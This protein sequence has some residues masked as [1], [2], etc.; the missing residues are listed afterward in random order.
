MERWA[1][2]RSQVWFAVEGAAV[3]VGAAAKIFC[4]VDS[5]AA[6]AGCA[7]FPGGGLK[8]ETAS[9]A[10]A[11]PAGSEGSEG[12]VGPAAAP[13]FAPHPAAGG[14]GSSKSSKIIGSIPL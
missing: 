3:S 14:H 10:V 7:V 4:P 13:S 12:A 9:P 2:A 1:A 8:A 6:P 11:G 5:S